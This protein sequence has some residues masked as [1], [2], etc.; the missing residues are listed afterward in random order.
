VYLVPAR[1]VSASPES[2]AA[3]ISRYGGGGGEGEILN[4]QML[5]IRAQEIGCADPLLC[6]E[7]EQGAC[8]RERRRHRPI[9][10]QTRPINSFAG[11]ADAVY[12]LCERKTLLMICFRRTGRWSIRG[13]LLEILAA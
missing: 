13:A 12:L 6:V 3:S 1:A 2:T 7:I 11:G 10:K 4:G 8:E 9:N 5:R